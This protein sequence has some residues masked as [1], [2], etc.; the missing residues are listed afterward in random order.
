MCN[1]VSYE[2]QKRTIVDKEWR[3]SNGQFY[4]LN[5]ICLATLAPIS[6]IVFEVRKQFVKICNNYSVS[7]ESDSEVNKGLISC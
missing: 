6:I 4:T 3:N 2:L 1:V 7:L 5:V